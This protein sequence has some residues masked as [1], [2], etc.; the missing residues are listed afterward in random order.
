MSLP[1]KCNVTDYYGFVA[2]F[3]LLAN[4]AVEHRLALRA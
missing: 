4:V 2:A 1:L 3:N